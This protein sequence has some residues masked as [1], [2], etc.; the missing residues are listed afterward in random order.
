MTNSF[1]N[2]IVKDIRILAAVR[3]DGFTEMPHSLLPRDDVVLRC[4]IQLY[5]GMTLQGVIAKELKHIV[6]CCDH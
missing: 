4:E 3:G 6:C 1:V 2:F 5:K